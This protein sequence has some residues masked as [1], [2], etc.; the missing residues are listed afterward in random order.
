MDK[1]NC[2]GFFR[3]IVF[4]FLLVIIL[5]FG[6]T[7]VNA[8]SVNIDV[9]NITVKDNSSTVTVGNP[10]IS[11]GVIDS[12][13]KF[14]E[15]GD[16][17]IFELTLKNNDTDKYKIISIT[18]NNENENLEIDYSYDE[19]FINQNE[20][21]KINIKMTYKKKLINQDK[22]SLND[23]EIKLIL[24]KEDGS[25]S[26]IVLNPKTGD[27]ILNYVLLNIISA[28][29]LFFILTKKRLKIVSTLLII[30]I[31]FIPIGTSAKE[32]YEV[33]ITF[34]NIE[35]KGE[36]EVYDVTLKPN[37]GSSTI[38]KN[39]AYGQP[40]GELP[41]VS[42]EGYEFDKWVDSNGDEVTNNTIITGPIEIEAKYTVIEYNIAYNLDGGIGSGENPTTYNIETETFTLLNPS[43]VGYE[44]TGWSG[45]D[46]TGDENLTVKVE[47]GTSKN[48]SY[49]AHFTANN[50]QVKFE[51]NGTNVTGTMHNQIFTYDI[52]SN[53]NEALYTREGYTFNGWNTKAD[54]SG[55][56][57]T[58]GQKVINLTVENNEVVNLYAQWSAIKYDV[59]FYPNGLPIEYQEVEYIEST[60]TQYIDTGFIPTSQTSLDIKA[61]IGQNTLLGA[62][63]NTLENGFV[64]SATIVNEYVRYFFN[65]AVIVRTKDESND[66]HR[67]IVKPT[68]VQ[69][70]YNGNTNT[71]N[72]TT[73][74]TTTNGS[75]IYL[76]ARNSRGPASLFSS[77]KIYF[78]KMWNDNVLE[79]D[80]IPCY[81]ISDGEIGL[82]DIVNGEFYKNDG[83]ETFNKGLDITYNDDVTIT[84][85]HFEFGTAQNLNTNVYSREGYTFVGWNT[86]ADGSGTSY[87]DG[88]EVN[89]LT[90]ENNDVIKLYAQWE[91]NS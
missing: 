31:I 71:I 36:F 25:T 14:N 76:F 7:R 57:Y 1:K 17:V 23:L 29:V 56:S 6:M 45:T 9:T 2:L 75:S 48:L 41:E 18:D 58:D 85:Q 52:D 65:P 11:N 40:L 87:T 70:I 21:T 79:R 16:F 63:G 67:I 78:L 10:N 19:S 89:N 22:L 28:L 53:L 51:K 61:S 88:Q 59:I 37:N 86:N 26:Q 81:R 84:N 91:V 12:D 60:G 43:K 27:N 55:T 42:K 66:V 74:G 50:Y 49:K 5:M 68:Y 38:V 47:K 72:Y 46:L 82:Y 90:V 13:I 80:Y 77:R 24:E 35:V 15:I 34:N 4:L 32:E 83:L 33:S 39:I 8:Q 44:F 62:E 73:V 64:I 20:T 69:S 30:S 54:G 3:N